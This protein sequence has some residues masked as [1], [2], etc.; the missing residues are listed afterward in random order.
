MKNIKTMLLGIALMI[1]SLALHT[2]LCSTDFLYTDFVVILGMIV[3]LI[4]FFVKEK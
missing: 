2:L 3:V 4:G 1:F